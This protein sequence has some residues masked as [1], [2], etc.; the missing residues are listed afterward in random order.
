[1]EPK[2]KD[3]RKIKG[4]EYSW[5]KSWPAITAKKTRGKFNAFYKLVKKTEEKPT[6]HKKSYEHHFVVKGEGVIILGK[7]K[8]KADTGTLVF[9]PTYTPHRVIPKTEM[10]IYV[11]S[12]P[13]VTKEDIFQFKD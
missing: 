3:L 12:V 10:W 1:M 2:I 13:P 4:K 9:I 6:Y 11:I 5:G 7:K 8:L